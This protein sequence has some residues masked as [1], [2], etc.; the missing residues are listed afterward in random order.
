S[1]EAAVER[2][3]GHTVA[4]DAQCP[5]EELVRLRGCRRIP[6]SHRSGAGSIVPDIRVRLIFGRWRDQTI[7]GKEG[8]AG[9]VGCRGQID[10]YRATRQCMRDRRGENEG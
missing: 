6:R 10:G 3:E 5:D 9:A 4:I 2:T 8:G 7:E 1:R